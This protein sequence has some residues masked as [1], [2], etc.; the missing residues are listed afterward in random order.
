MKR[1]A[2]PE[3]SEEEISLVSET[4]RSRSFVEG[5]NARELEKEFA[6]FVGAKHAICAVNG[7]AALHLAMEGLNL[8]PGTEVITP[9]F[10]FIASANTIC[11]GGNIP[12]FC[13]I[14]PDTF[15]IDPEKIEELITANTKGILPVHIFGLPADMKTIVDIAEDRD[16]K[17]IEDACQAHGARIDGKHVGTFGDV[18]CFSFYA[19]KNMITGEG[20]MIVTDD[21]GLAERIRSIKNHGRGPKGG[22]HHHLIAYNYR[23]AD[24]LAAIGLV[25]LRKLPKML[26]Q[27][28]KNA[29]SIR[30]TIK[31]I[32]QLHVQTIASGVTHGHYICAPVV[33]DQKIKVEKIIRELNERG[34]ASRQIYSI[35]CHQ[36][37]TYLEGLKEWRWSKFVKYPDYSDIKLPVTERI[38]FNHF[39]V[40]I[41]TGI[42]EKELTY[43]QDALTDFFS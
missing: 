23:L 34:I 24:P 18:G 21:D 17:I 36:Q 35:P 4:I 1:I 2:Q 25:Q 30:N 32:D 43:I 26:E 33:N 37:P 38:A 12:I 10:T 42:T 5:K 40:P 15:N 7:T 31:E 3:I 16:L 22:Y 39:E 13:E 9:A 27:R 11:F 8:S 19:T 20:G 29:E 41:H 28:K 6:E 14:D